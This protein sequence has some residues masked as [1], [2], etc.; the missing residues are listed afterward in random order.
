VARKTGGE[1]PVSI[2]VRRLDGRRVQTPSTISVH[3]VQAESSMLL[4]KIT[5]KAEEGSFEDWKLKR[6]K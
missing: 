3:I 5:K 4:S 2:A 6:K 1:C